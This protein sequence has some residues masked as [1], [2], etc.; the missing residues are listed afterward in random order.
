MVV[1]I[2]WCTDTGALLNQYEIVEKSL[3]L[4]ETW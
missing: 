4:S 1:L 2:A 3:L